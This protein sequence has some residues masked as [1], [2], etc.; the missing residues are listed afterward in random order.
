[1]GFFILPVSPVWVHKAIQNG[2]T[3]VRHKDGYERLT[4]LTGVSPGWPCAFTHIEQSGYLLL[5]SRLYNLIRYKKTRRGVDCASRQA[6]NV[7]HGALRG[8]T[9]SLGQHGPTTPPVWASQGTMT[10]ASMVRRKG[11]QSHGR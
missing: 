4:C 9:M 7:R 5:P 2:K 1:M 10:C 11:G 8:R 3:R 6:Y